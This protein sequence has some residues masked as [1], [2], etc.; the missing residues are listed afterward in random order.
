LLTDDAI[1]HGKHVE[2]LE[3]AEA[4]SLSESLLDEDDELPFEITPETLE[5]LNGKRVAECH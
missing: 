5:K 1:E 4:K 3:S 2:A